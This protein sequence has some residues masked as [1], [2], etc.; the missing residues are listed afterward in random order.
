MLLPFLAAAVDLFARC[1][2]RR[3]RIGPALRSYRSRL[4]FWAWVGALFLVFAAFGAWGGGGRRPSSLD[5][6]SWPAGTLVVL[7]LLGAIGWLVARERLLPRRPIRVEEQIAGH[8]GALLALAVVGL[9]VA[10]TNPF[11]LVFLLPCLHTWLWL[12]QV[13]SRPLA[14]RAAVF[15][16]GLAGPA[17]LLWSF[18]TQYG[19]GLDAPWYLAKLFASGYAPRTLLVVALAWL[20]AAGQLVAL[21]GNRYAP[22]PGPR[23]RARR[24]PIRELIRALVLAQRK[25]T[26]SSEAKRAVQ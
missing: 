8:T 6:V 20:A 21:A 1:R 11:T 3:I 26:L 10:A 13:Q 19:L 4:A 5:S 16:V 17:L 12:P 22:Y 9:L 15:L 25:R 2:R 7:G 18:A 24:G 14:L 23:E